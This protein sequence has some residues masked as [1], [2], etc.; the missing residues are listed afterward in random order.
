M[1]R[2]GSLNHIYRLV[3]SRVTHC[4]VAVAE[5]TRARSKGSGKSARRK[6]VAARLSLAA[7]SFTSPL[8]LAGPTGGQLVSGTGTISQSGATTTIK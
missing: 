6:L 2:H 3:W 5:T 4:W 8:A 1:K 7:I